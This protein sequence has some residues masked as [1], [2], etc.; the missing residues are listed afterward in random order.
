MVKIF[1][2]NLAPHTTTS[3]LRLL[4]SQY[5][6]IAECDIVRN[7]GFVHM[8]DKAEAEEA[9]RNL[10]HYELNGQPMNIELSYGKSRASTKLYVGNIACTNQE[11]RV[12][13]EEF[14]TVL[15]CDI[16][17]D[18]AFVHMERVE[19]AMQA[20]SKLDNTTFKGKQMSVKLSTSRLHTAPRMGQ[21]SGYRRGQEGHWS[22]ECPLDQNGYH[23]NGSEPK[24]G[25]YS[26]LRFGGHDHGW[27]YQQG[28]SG[29]PDYGGS[30]PPV[31]AFSWGSGHSNV[32]GYGSGTGF[33]NAMSYGAPPG[34]GI[35]TSAKHSMAEMYGCEAAYGSSSSLYGAVPAYPV[36]QSSFENRD[37]YGAVN[38]YRANPY[39]GSYFE[40]CHSVSL[41]ARSSSSSAVMR[42]CLPPSS[43]DSNEH[44]PPPELMSSYYTHERS[45]IRRV[46]PE[47][48]G[49]RF[50]DLCLFPTS[51]LPKSSAY[52][53]PPGPL[54]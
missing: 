27:V 16:V 5:G 29:N 40:G 1:I 22:E 36:Q 44:P 33:E 51:S 50:E 32:A 47:A 41:P 38:L 30:Y 34:Y 18:Y 2:G 43:L 9:I 6:K 15:K 11:L 54:F 46:Q 35:S 28:F 20:I 7:F 19:D 13:F 25:G 24:S 42:E 14:G 12:R 45:P 53:L 17:R 10:H 31:H 8:D 4:F 23:R 3:D 52:D 26:T 48:N 37:P 21:R 49:Y 39:G